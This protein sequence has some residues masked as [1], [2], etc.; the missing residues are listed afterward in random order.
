MFYKVVFYV[1]RNKDNREV[2]NFKERKQAFLVPDDYDKEKL[3]NKF[4]EFA[5][6][7]QPGE[8]SRFYISVNK[9]DSVK[10]HR[11][12]M[13]WLFDNPDY[14]LSKLEPKLAGLAAEPHCAAEKKWLFDFDNPSQEA[15]NEFQY[16]I[17]QIDPTVNV[18]VYRT[19][20]GFAVIVDHGFDARTL[21]E[22][23]APEDKED[24]SQKKS[25]MLKRDDMLLTAW[26][27]NK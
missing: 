27:V 7:G 17:K 13:H 9:R 24:K 23:W 21:I 19:V 11:A 3:M 26:E 16:D 25:D 20:H 6:K 1:S 22:K 18:E 12:L 15:V 10:V 14:D 5:K 2:E 4:H 8:M